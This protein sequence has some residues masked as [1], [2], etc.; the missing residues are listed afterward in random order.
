MLVFR[1]AVKRLGL[2]TVVLVATAAAA[3]VLSLRPNQPP[4]RPRRTPNRTAIDQTQR[5]NGTPNWLSRVK[6]V[7][8][9]AKWTLAE[10]C[11]LFCKAD[12]QSK[13]RVTS[14][15]VTPVEKESS[16][17]Q[18]VVL[19][20]A[21]VEHL[22]RFA[23]LFDTYLIVR[24]D[25]DQAEHQVTEALKSAG[26]FES[27]LLDPR[28]LLFTETDLGRVSVA[29]QIEPQLHIDETPEVITALQRFLFCVALVS[30]DLH[31]MKTDACATNVAK[32]TSLSSFFTSKS[33]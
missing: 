11:D 9:G 33:S 17:I 2:G 31:S 19:R 1:A 23:K 15:E 25:D 18:R 6:K 13:S 22:K 29:R 24:I 3:F 32:F 10:R 21:A 26:M 4:R 12:Q 14:D 28:K 8:I 30:A 20:T 16:D 7:T 27:G 5:T